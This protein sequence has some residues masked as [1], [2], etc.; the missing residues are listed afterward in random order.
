MQNYQVPEFFNYSEIWLLPYNSCQFS[1]QNDALQLFC[2][3]AS[4]N[5]REERHHFYHVD[6]SNAIVA[7]HEG[8]WFK[9]GAQKRHR[10]T[11]EMG[12]SESPLTDQLG[13]TICFSDELTQILLN[14]T[15]VLVKETI[16]NSWKYVNRPGSRHFYQVKTERAK[17]VATITR[18]RSSLHCTTHFC[19]PFSEWIW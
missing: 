8:Q 18:T 10:S 11:E 5:P 6:V 7:S 3:Q 19:L 14:N 2:Q 17:P 4:L 1:K 16:P 13:E 9:A 12:K 15:W